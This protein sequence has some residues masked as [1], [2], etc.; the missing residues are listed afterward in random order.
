MTHLKEGDS[1]PE[2][3]GKNELG[4]M[5]SNDDFKSKKFILFFYPKDDTPG[6]T[7]AACSLRD[8]YADLKAKGYELLGVSPD[9]EKKHQGFIK[10]YGFPFHLISDTNQAVM[11]A[12]GV[13]GPKKFMGREFDGVHRTTFVVDEA[14]KIEKV[15]T[16][17]RTKDHAAQIL[18]AIS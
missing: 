6:C 18:E 17:V 1:I 12:F 14:G 5:M 16:K 2:F 10:K 8:S 11:N 9:S 7:A 13:W 4:E 15:F 3:S